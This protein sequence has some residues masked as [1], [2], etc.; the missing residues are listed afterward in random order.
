MIA[1]MLWGCAWGFVMGY[2]TAKLRE[3]GGDMTITVS[4]DVFCD[5]EGCQRWVQGVTGRTSRSADARDRAR[6]AGWVCKPGRDLCPTC[7]KLQQETPDEA[8]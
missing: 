5:G 6:K 4:T 1:F 2:A 8:R 3:R 7:A